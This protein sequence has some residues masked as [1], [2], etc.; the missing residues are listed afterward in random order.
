MA[1][2]PVE[3]AWADVVISN[4]AI[5]LTAHKA[6]VF[7]EAYRMLMPGGRGLLR[8]QEDLTGLRSRSSIPCC[9]SCRAGRGGQPRAPCGGDNSEGCDSTIGLTLFKVA[10]RLG[11]GICH[12]REANDRPARRRSEG[13]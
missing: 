7:R 10:L 9:L 5:N 6:C 12:M 11:H 13:V 3:D 1:A 4:G 2:V 8:V